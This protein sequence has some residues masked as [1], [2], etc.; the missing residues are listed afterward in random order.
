MSKNMSLATSCCSL[1]PG[2][3]ALTL[4]ALARRSASLRT[5]PRVGSVL[6][7]TRRSDL[8][9]EFLK[10]LYILGIYCILGI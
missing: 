4:R 9:M 1:S 5:R 3:G 10:K 8:E 7:L 6:G 2:H